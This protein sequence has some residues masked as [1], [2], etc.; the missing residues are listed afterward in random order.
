MII[1]FSH[2]ALGHIV[3]NEIGNRFV[4]YGNSFETQFNWEVENDSMKRS[5]QIEWYC[6]QIKRRLKKKSAKNEVFDSK[7]NGH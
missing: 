6:F 5:E 3:S 2:V 7:K 1:V 4:N